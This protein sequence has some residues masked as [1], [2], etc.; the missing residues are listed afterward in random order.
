MTTAVYANH[1]ARVFANSAATA[2]SW[3]P[4]VR[5]R[6]LRR[7]RVRTMEL[8]RRRIAVYRDFDGC[9]HAIDARCPHLGADLAL[10]TVEADNLRCAFHGWCFGSDGACRDA[11][12]HA[13]PPPRRTRVY[14]CE[15]RWG[16][17]WVF[18][19]PSPLFSL[20]VPAAGKWWSLMLPP[21]RIGCHP[22][23]VLANGLDVAHYET[24]HGMA[25]T[26]PPRLAVGS[27]EV[28]VTMR[29]RPRSRFWRVV[30]GSTCGDIVATFTTVG[31][32][33]AWTSVD[34]PVRFHVLFSGRPDI[35]GK[36]VTRTIFLF[37]AG[38]GFDC[39]RA[40]GLMAML[41]HDDRRVL[42]TI[43]FRPEF[44]AADEPMRAFARVVDGL[45][46]W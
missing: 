22:H 9:V 15:E 5:S 32:S 25:F 43:D 11:P 4:A 20:P 8:A 40:I 45:G 19:G 44:D 36:C 6:S 35:E 38:S 16:L 30:S 23:L 21:Q 42:E 46:A 26:H 33:L 24:L 37:P 31:G 39:V 1:D 34:A 14:P 2:R 3:Y 18:N 17:V 29:G 13:A 10:G 12:G 27:H 41:L 7:G 28:S